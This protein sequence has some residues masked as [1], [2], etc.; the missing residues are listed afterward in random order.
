MPQVVPHLWDIE[1]LKTQRRASIAAFRRERIGEPLEQY[2]LY[3]QA[4]R[5][6]TETILELS[7]DLRRVRE[8]AAEIL[9][10][11]ELV[12][13]ARYLASPP[14]SKDDLETVADTTLAR[15]L[16]RADPERAAR[17]MDTILL[18]LDRERFPWVAEDREATEAE[19]NTAVIST[20]A[21]RAFR[22]V[23]T[24][25]RNEGKKSQESQVKDFLKEHCGFTEV[26]A[27]KIV[28]LS[29]APD[30]G[31]FC[32]ETDVGA[33]KADICVR[34][35]DGRLMPIECKVSNSST[36]SYKRINNDAAVKAVRWRE[37]FGTQNVVPTAVLSG[38]FA[39]ANLTYAQNHDLYLFW[40]HDLH[41][42]RVFV[43]AARP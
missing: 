32:G 35:W 31:E 27:R 34:L 2:L 4:A 17:L 21:M 6:A 1:E 42:L 41:P 12:D 5:E 3:F 16:V 28:N 24:W 38:V 18:G 8:V 37:E 26:P 10:D 14:I 22:Q 19:W 40:S 33:R 9:S 30:L 13:T 25:R 39:L 29:M 20:A 15:T 11:E 23:E 36:N 43:E 7:L